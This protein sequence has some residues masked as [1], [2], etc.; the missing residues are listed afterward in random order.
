LM[1]TEP[2]GSGDQAI[3]SARIVVRGLI[4]GL[5]VFGGLAF[6]LGPMRPSQDPLLNQVMPIVLGV[7]AG[8]SAIGYFTLRRGF[9]RACRGGVP[10]VPQAGAVGVARLAAYRGFVVSG[11]GLIEGPGF[12]AGVTYVVTGRP[13]ALVAMGCAVVLLVVH[14][15]STTELL[16]R[17][18]EG[19]P[20][21]G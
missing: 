3:R 5:L 19:G 10:G 1:E 6:A 11:G 18:S 13:V 4:M 21:G 17:G 9:A 12:L 16:S 14:L 15:T 20:I 7:L 2:A 8:G